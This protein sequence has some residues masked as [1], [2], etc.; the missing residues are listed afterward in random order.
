MNIQPLKD[1]KRLLISLL[2]NLLN[3]FKIYDILKNNDYIIFLKYI[4]PLIN[5]FIVL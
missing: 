4:N 3:I 2:Y 1:L 5:I